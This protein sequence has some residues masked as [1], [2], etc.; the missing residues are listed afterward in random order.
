MRIVSELYTYL[1]QELRSTLYMGV[2][3]GG[4]G[5]GDASPQFLEWG[6]RISNYPPP[7]LFDMF[8]EILFLS[9]PKT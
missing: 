1:E 8:N 6:G 7:P 3:P 5:G 2:N 9:Y 4:M